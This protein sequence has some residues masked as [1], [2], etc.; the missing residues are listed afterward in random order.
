MKNAIII[1]VRKPE[2]GKVKTRLAHAIGEEKA[3]EV[4]CELLRLTHAA[5]VQCGADKFI[6]YAG[7][8]EEH[9]IWEDHL[10]QKRKQAEGDLGYKMMQAFREVFQ[11][12][13]TNVVITGSDCP[14]ITAQLLEEA[15]DKIQTADAV[16]GPAADGGYYLLGLKQLLPSIFSNIPWSTSQVLPATLAALQ[17]AGMQYNLLQQLTDIDTA[18]DL[19]ARGYPFF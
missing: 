2:L 8:I 10:F 6:F 13:Y 14:D 12:G 18:E 7:G 15:F 17:H 11:M 3:L 1:F 5:V 16:I 19:G 9:D 4:Y